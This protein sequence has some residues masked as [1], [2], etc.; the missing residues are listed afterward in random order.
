MA[1]LL[2]GNYCNLAINVL[3]DER[4]LLGQLLQ[5]SGLLRV[6]QTGNSG[7]FLRIR[8]DRYRQ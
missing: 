6:F 7:S 8:A 2:C 3:P 4:V 5:R 1:P